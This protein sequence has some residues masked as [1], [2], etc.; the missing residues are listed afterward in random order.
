MNKEKCYVLPSAGEARGRRLPGRGAP[1]AQ[2]FEKPF[3]RLWQSVGP[4]LAKVQVA[5]GV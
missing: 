2:Q 1:S 4:V 3:K 5:E